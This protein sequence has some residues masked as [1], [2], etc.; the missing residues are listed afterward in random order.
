VS[1]AIGLRSTYGKPYLLPVRDFLLNFF[2]PFLWTIALNGIFGTGESQVLRR[3][4]N[5]Y[6]LL[7]NHPLWLLGFNPPKDDK[8]FKRSRRA[9]YRHFGLEIDP[10][11]SDEADDRESDERKK[12]DSNPCSP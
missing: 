4:A 7:D 1:K 3:E 2:C 10:N 12:Q 6:I 9:V 5:R 8:V 11:D